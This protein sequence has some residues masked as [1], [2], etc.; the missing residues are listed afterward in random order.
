MGLF[1]GIAAP[2]GRS[3]AAADLARLYGL[4]VLLVLDV[5]GQSQTAAAVAKGFATYDPAVEIAGVVLNKLGSE[6]HRKLAGEAIEAIGLPVVGAVMRD[7]SVTLPERHLGLVQASEHADLD[8]HLDRLADLMERSLDID[9]IVGLMRAAR[10]HAR[11]ERRPPCPRPASASRSPRT[12]PSPSSI[13]IWR[14]SGARR[15]PSSC[16][17]RRSPTRRRRADCD[18]CWLPGGYPGT[19]CRPPRAGRRISWP[20]SARFAETRPVHGEC[21]GFMVLGQTLEDADG[22]TH[23]DARPARPFDEL[24]QA[25]DESRLPPGDASRRLPHRPARRHV[26]RGHEFHYAQMIDAGSDAPLADLPTDRAMPLG[27]FGGR[28]GH[29]T[30]AFFHAIARA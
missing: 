13:R 19:P 6:R 20:A 8:A 10:R 9:A 29:V 11:G 15:A 12:P 30:G 2:P 3:G 5:S 4:P 7:A 23:A 24:R 21:G 14:A 17:S 16:P 25:Q 27:A 1:D 18:V 28:R 22:V 26:L